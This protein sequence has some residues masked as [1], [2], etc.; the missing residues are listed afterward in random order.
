MVLDYYSA[1]TLK[2]CKCG[3]ENCKCE[4][5]LF[6]LDSFLKGKF[7]LSILIAEKV[8]LWPLIQFTGILYVGLD[9]PLATRNANFSYEKYGITY[10]TYNNKLFEI[11]KG[12]AITP[13]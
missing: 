8:Y 6:V 2:D 1:N 7:S 3:A 5:G 4:L 12:E 11:E 9:Q 13:W 10:N